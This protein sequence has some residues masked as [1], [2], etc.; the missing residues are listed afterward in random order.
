MTFRMVTWVVPCPKLVFEPR[1][2]LLA[3]TPCCPFLTTAGVGEKNGDWL[4]L[5]HSWNFPGLTCRVHPAC[6]EEEECSSLVSWMVMRPCRIKGPDTKYLLTLCQLSCWVSSYDF[7]IAFPNGYHWAHMTDEKTQPPRGK[8]VSV[9]GPCFLWALMRP[10][11]NSA[12]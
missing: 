5:D 4:L 6:G 10:F 2:Q 12:D 9:I 11:H 8:L 3:T 1:T 7:P